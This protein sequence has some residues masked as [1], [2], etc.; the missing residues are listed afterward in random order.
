M[1]PALKHTDLLEEE[2]E[3][4]DSDDSDTLP[5]S[6]SI[7]GSRSASPVPIEEDIM[8]EMGIE[9][10]AEYIGSG[11]LP[12]SY[13]FK[14]TSS[15]ELP[16]GRKRVGSDGAQRLSRR[17]AMTA[18]KAKSLKDSVR[19]KRAHAENDSASGSSRELSPIP[20]SSLPTYDADGLTSLVN[21]QE[22]IT[23]FSSGVSIRIRRPTPPYPQ[24]TYYLHR[25]G[26]EEEMS[27]AVVRQE[28][29]ETHS[30][31]PTEDLVSIPQSHARVDDDDLVI[32]LSP[33]ESPPPVSSEGEEAHNASQEKG[34]STLK[35][36][37]LG[38]QYW[39]A[40]EENRQ[41]GVAG[42]S[43]KQASL[44]RKK[45]AQVE[46]EFKK[47]V[48]SHPKETTQVEELGLSREPG[49]EFK[50]V[51][52]KIP[53]AEEFSKVHVPL[54]AKKTAPPLDATDEFRKVN[55]SSDSI[56][57]E[58]RKVTSGKP[59]GSERDSMGSEVSL[60]EFQLHSQSSTDSLPFHETRGYDWKRRREIRRK[61]R[62]KGRKDPS[63]SRVP[64]SDETKDD[65]PPMRYR[66]RSGAF[67][68]HKPKR[69]H[70]G[71]RSASPLLTD[72]QILKQV[73]RETS[74]EHESPFCAY[75]PAGSEPGHLPRHGSQL[76]SDFSPPND[77]K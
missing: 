1:A 75:R 46:S 34:K 42:D 11:S 54:R 41:Q 44:E 61:V 77:G 58:F 19:K 64:A 28:S 73:H 69:G 2:E 50:K 63:P 22:Q 8:V 18:K 23:Q 16:H 37:K 5:G 26:A 76:S 51:G 30:P 20:L 21:T 36:D 74:P 60:D 27:E 65:G 15:L 47:V 7:S 71:E 38:Q 29:T 45:G 49:T 32:S 39:Y 66:T 48:M 43:P 67:S 13:R 57:G 17:G 25:S 33:T 31:S 53:A 62:G 4:E 56:D 10:D 68:E 70:L 6:L 14:E 59:Q 9:A 55:T 35:E 24:P 52:Q 12:H 40:R 3:E 72:T